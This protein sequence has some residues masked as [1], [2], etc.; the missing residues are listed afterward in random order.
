MNRWTQSL[1][2][3]ACEAEE[4]CGIDECERFAETLRTKADDPAILEAT[5]AAILNSGDL[6]R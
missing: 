5:A 3:A 2:D 6:D 1:I 4:L